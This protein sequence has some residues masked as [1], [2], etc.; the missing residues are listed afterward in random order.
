MLSLSWFAP[1]RK[2]RGKRSTQSNQDRMRPPGFC[3][4]AVVFVAACL[5]GGD[6]LLSRRPAATHRSSSNSFSLGSLLVPVQAPAE[7]YVRISPNEF[8]KQV[9]VCRAIGLGAVGLVA[10][11]WQ[12]LDAALQSFYGSHLQ[13][14]PFFRHYAFEPI[15]A[16]TC[17]ALYIAYFAVLDHWVP[18][19]WRYRLQAQGPQGDSMAAWRNRLKDALTYEV[20]L[21]LGV[22]IPF[23]GI[24][25]ARRVHQTTSLGLVIREVLLALVIYDALFYL[26]HN[27]LHRVPWLYHTVHAKHHS[28]P[29]VR[30]GDSVRHSFLDGAWDVVC[31]VAALMVLRANALS[32]SVFNIVAI[33]LIVEAHCGSNFPWALA[34]LVPGGI[35]AGAKGHDL[36]HQHGGARNLGKFFSVFDRL[37]GTAA[38]VPTVA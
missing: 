1:I 32:R 26:G 28:E 35:F 5:H 15:L 14:W 23:G 22:W 4:T 21:Y 10:S 3:L 36:H 9:R 17:F 27:A 8:K 34:N 18:A 38:A 29:V 24:V 25:R 30:A 13:S 31:A 33:F 7:S 11:N 20:P 37:F 16:S 19:A 2:G 6:A 12:A